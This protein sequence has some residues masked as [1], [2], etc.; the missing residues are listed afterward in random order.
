MIRLWVQRALNQ[1]QTQPEMAVLVK[2]LWAVVRATKGKYGQIRPNFRDC[3]R[4]KCGQIYGLSTCGLFKKFVWN[5]RSFWIPK[6][7]LNKSEVDNAQRS[8][9]WQNH[10][11]AEPPQERVNW[12]KYY[13]NHFC[14]VRWVTES[15]QKRFNWGHR[16][17][18][19]WLNEFSFTR[20]EDAQGTTTQSHIS[21]S[22]LVN[23]E[24]V[25][26]W[27]PFWG[28]QVSPL[29]KLSN[30]YYNTAKPVSEVASFGGLS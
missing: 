18:V 7:I 4:R 30:P 25:S 13:A 17:R 27:T 9:V 26:H 12:G 21:P 19:G 16:F 11:V 3:I 15:P 24:N 23:E 10:C 14:A 28:H 6:E 20:A 29:H 1:T 22:L 5:P 8:A 2:D